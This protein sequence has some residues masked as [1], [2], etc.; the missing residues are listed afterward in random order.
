MRPSRRLA[1][2][3]RALACLGALVLGACASPA[4]PP[5]AEQPPELASVSYAPSPSRLRRLTEAQYHHTVRDLFGPE[6]VPPARLEPDASVAGFLA[7]GA[8]ASSIS[9]RGVELY[10]AGAFDLAEQV[11][12]TPD[13]RQRVLDGCTTEDRACAE[14]VVTRFG[15]R[16]WRRPLTDA[17]AARLL[18]IYDKAFAVYGGFDASVSFVIGALLQSPHFLFRSEVGPADGSAQPFDDWEMASRLSFLLWDS[19]PDDAL[20]DAAAAGQLT[21]DEGLRAQ[22][23]RMLADDRARDGVRAFFAELL[24]LERLDYLVK[25]PEIFPHIGPEVAPS[26]REETLRLVEHIIIDQRA[27]YRDLFTTRTTFVN[28]KLAS[29]YNIPAPVREGF[30]QTEHPEDSARRGILGHVSV[31]A[32]HA[33]PVSTSPTLR[34]MFIRQRLLCQG[35][36]PPPANVDTSIP[37]PSGTTLTM[38]DRLAE[39]LTDPTCASCHRLTDPIGLGLE[40]F[41]GIGRFRSRDNGVLIDASGELN[42]Q[43]FADAV[44]LAERLHDHPELS[45]CLTEQLH[46]Y[47]TGKEH[48]DAQQD[49]LDALALRFAM[50]G[51]D[52]LALIEDFAMSRAFRHSAPA[53]QDALLELNTTEQ[54]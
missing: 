24:E 25:A 27:D 1:R 41:D 28:R 5:P 19:A 48:T 10:E 16:A 31:L 52:V 54:P 34:G 47:A 9:S 3:P 14:A 30:G 23:Q 20:L 45:R 37:E 15:R 17:E 39:H 22:I 32:T 2:T 33:H 50:G 7:L 13:A 11:L 12:A 49:L 43:P 40:Q 21:D 35:V 6:V 8:T 29:I 53:S 4:D 38:R 46:R 18:G 51:H 36:P 42:G 26:A 44:G